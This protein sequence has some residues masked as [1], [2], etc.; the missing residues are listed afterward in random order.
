MPSAVKISNASI[1]RS[2]L[3]IPLFLRKLAVGRVFHKSPNILSKKWKIDYPLLGVACGEI[4]PKKR[5]SHFL[6]LPFYLPP[7]KLWVILL[8][9]H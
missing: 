4:P 1:I 3:K 9:S 6:T 2:F 5:Q 8:P 7:I